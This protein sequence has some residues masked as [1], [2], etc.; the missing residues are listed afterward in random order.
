MYRCATRV[1]DCHRASLTRVVGGPR[2]DFYVCG[3]CRR[4]CE[5]V[6]CTDGGFV[7]GPQSRRLAALGVLL[8]ALVTRRGRYADGVRVPSYRERRAGRRL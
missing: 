1:S 3:D 2:R 6:G 5:P 4:V 7:P 8:D